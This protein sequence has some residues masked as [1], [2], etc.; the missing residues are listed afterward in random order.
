V[1]KINQ[2][3]TFVIVAAIAAILGTIILTMVMDTSNIVSRTLNDGISIVQNVFVGIAHDVRNF[4]QSTFDLFGTHEENQRVRAQMYTNE[5]ANIRIA[6]LEEELDDL[7]AAFEIDA[8]LIDFERVL[9]TT[10]GR[11]INNWYDFIIVNQGNS[12]GIE[13]GMAVV[14]V[15]GFLIGRVTEVGNTAS[16]IHLMRPHNPDIRARVEICGLPGSQGTFHGY[17]AETDE[18]VVRQVS[19]DVDIEV[20]ARVITT[21]MGDV[22]PRG[23]LAGYVTRSEPAALSQTL[24]LE[25]HVDYDNLRFVFII[26]RS[27]PEP[28]MTPPDTAESETTEPEATEPE[29]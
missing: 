3:K 10:V 22:F 25:N 21:G 11:D 16:R 7:R 6:R 27:M 13:P 14:S 18:L 8:T 5:L 24:F 20:G 15:E 23:L 26:K 4:G 12:H 9:A 2:V 28:D 17:D 19:L 1:R 29:L